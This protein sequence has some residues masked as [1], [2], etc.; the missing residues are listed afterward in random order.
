MFIPLEVDLKFAFRALA[1]ANKNELSPFIVQQVHVL[2]REA[3]SVELGLDLPRVVRFILL[4][5]PYARGSAA[6]RIFDRER[7]AGTR[8]DVEF[9]LYWP[10][11]RRRL[12]EFVSEEQFPPVMHEHV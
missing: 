9:L 8:R 2:G 3:P 7:E 12:V 11:M 1:R 4:T 5:Q 6:F 10:L